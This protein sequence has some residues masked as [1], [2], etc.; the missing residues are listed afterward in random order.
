MAPR[1]F[2]FS[3]MEKGLIKHNYAQ[4]GAQAEAATYG[5]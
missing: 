3:S 4:Q 1:W 5:R 2:S